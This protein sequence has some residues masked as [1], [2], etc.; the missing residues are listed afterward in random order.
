MRVLTIYLQFSSLFVTKACLW[1]DWCFKC[2]WNYVKCTCTVYQGLDTMVPLKF[3]LGYAFGVQGSHI[4][5]ATWNRQDYKKVDE[6]ETIILV[7]KWN[8]AILFCALE[9]NA[10]LIVR[11][12]FDTF[13]LQI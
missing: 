13:E 3:M 10:A 8:S 11:I 7:K 2:L 5:I 6:N 9:I 4:F 12:R 1:S